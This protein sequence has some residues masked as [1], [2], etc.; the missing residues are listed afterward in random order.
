M[1][2]TLVSTPVA[3]VATSVAPVATSVAPVSTFVAS[4]ILT[5]DPRIRVNGALYPLLCPKYKTLYCV[6]VIHAVPIVQKNKKGSSMRFSTYSFFV[7][8]RGNIKTL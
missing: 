6:L 2:V 1:L 3:P 8:R 4:G 5:C 7:N